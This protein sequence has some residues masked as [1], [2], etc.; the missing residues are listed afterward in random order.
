M[1]T[2]KNFTRKKLSL[3]EL[4]EFL[5]NAS[6]ACL[7]NVCSRQYFYDVKQAYEEH[8]ME[9]L[10]KKTRGKP[11]AVGHTCS[12]DGCHAVPINRWVQWGL[13]NR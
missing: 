12:T 7:I 3:L 9:R 11:E 4:S 2:Q 10:I 1:T 6:Q 5:T 8:G 13:I